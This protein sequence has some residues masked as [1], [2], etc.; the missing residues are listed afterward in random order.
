M[1]TTRQRAKS[2]PGKQAAAKTKTQRNRVIS[3]LAKELAAQRQLGAAIEALADARRY[4]MSPEAAIQRLS[5]SGKISGVDSQLV[6]LMLMQ[7][8]YTRLGGGGGTYGNITNFF[9]ESMRRASVADSR[10]MY[11]MD[12]QT[13]AAVDMWVDSGLG[14][15]V[16][17]TPNDPSLVEVW[18]EFWKAPRNAYVVGA[19]KIHE[20]VS[21]QI[22]D[23]EVFFVIWASTL[24]GTCTIRRMTTDQF[25]DIVCD[26]NDPAVP[27][28]Y[29]QN[30][31]DGKTVYYTDY[32]VANTL[33]ES[34]K[35]RA[36]V[37]KLIGEKAEQ[38][39]IEAAQLMAQI[40]SQEMPPPPQGAV[41]A[42]DLRPNTRVV[43]VPM[44]RNMI[45]KRG[46][47]QLRQALVWFRAYRD[48][49]G[50]RATVAKKAAMY[51]EKV[52]AKNSGQRQID[53]IVAR[54]QSSLVNEGTGLDR[55][56]N[57]TAGQTWIQNEQVNREW[58]ARDTGAPGA[59]ID[60][61]SILGQ[62]AAGARTPLGWMGRPDAWQ[63]RAV[64]KEASLPWYEQIQ[65]YQT[66]LTSVFSDI[67]EVV[68][69]M[70][71]EYGGKS[72]QDF[73]CEVSLDSPFQNDIDEIAAIMGAVTQAAIGGNIDADIAKRA[74]AELTRLALSSL[75]IRNTKPIL[76]PEAATT[77]AGDKGMPE[78]AREIKAAR[79]ELR[80]ARRALEAGT[81]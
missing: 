41:N 63:N 55:N 29:I 30:T 6:D 25:S 47:P 42:D 5:E 32:R 71:N 20:N 62:G 77:T 79:E 37:N 57:T 53:N 1:P 38:S 48:F 23:G 28:Y 58:M 13:S 27:V 70:A 4:V 26:P 69:R 66:F 14:Q 34:N 40:K 17:I 50:D 3:P 61:L 35:A 19:D 67:V 10:L 45:G 16:V 59:Q 33:S 15:E 46:W 21:T 68:G 56:Q 8:G 11:Q 60:G 7:S 18:D 12:V 78:L 24:D 65:R 76:E 51:V 9:N 54:L 43:V 52:T 80:E 2:K 39:V 44:Q 72:I 75:G 64:A 73:S 74:N 81:Q 31:L 49:I 36:H 22:Q